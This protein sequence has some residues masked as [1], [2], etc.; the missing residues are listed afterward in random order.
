[1]NE[2]TVN[3]YCDVWLYVCA[4]MLVYATLVKVKG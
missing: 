2:L 1:M 4:V 3:D